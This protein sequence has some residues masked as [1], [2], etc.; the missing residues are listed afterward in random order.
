MNHC[1]H[2]YILL[3]GWQQSRHLGLQIAVNSWQIALLECY[4]QQCMMWEVLAKKSHVACSELKQPNAVC[5]SVCML[6]TISTTSKLSQDWCMTAIHI[7]M[8]LTHMK[9]VVNTY[10]AYTYR[11]PNWQFTMCACILQ[12]CMQAEH[13][14]KQPVSWFCQSITEVRSLGLVACMEVGQQYAAPACTL[15]QCMQALQ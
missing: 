4:L 7:S 5:S 8:Q 15:H 3:N 14:L 2:I 11:E 13:K 6:C 9:L 10:E 12:Q 1:S